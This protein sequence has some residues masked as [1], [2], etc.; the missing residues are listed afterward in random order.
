MNFRGNLPT[1]PDPEP[2][3][4]KRCARPS[5]EGSAVAGAEDEAQ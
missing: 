3:V 1:K 2:P 5:L 4:E